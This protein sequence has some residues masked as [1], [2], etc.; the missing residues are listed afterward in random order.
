MISVVY[1]ANGSGG[2][3]SPPLIIIDGYQRRRSLAR[4]DAMI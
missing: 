4:L 1:A 2:T 3:G